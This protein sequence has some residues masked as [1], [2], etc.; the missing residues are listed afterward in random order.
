MNVPLE[1]LPGQQIEVAQLPSVS[2]KVDVKDN[3]N[4]DKSTNIQGANVNDAQVIDAKDN[5]GNS[6]EITAETAPEKDNLNTVIRTVGPNIKLPDNS[7][8]NITPS[9]D[10]KYLIETDAR[11]TNYKKWLSSIDIVTNEQLHKRLGDG[12]YEQRLVRD[13]LVATT[14]QRLLGNYQSDEEQYRHLLTNGVAFGETFNLTPGIALTPEQMANLTTDI[15]WMVNKEVTLP[16]GRVEKVSVPQVYVRAR[17]GDLNGNGALLAGRNVSVD[18]AGDI[19]NS[20]E[21]SSRELIDLRAENI[22]NSG[23]IQGKNVQLNALKD[24]HNVGGEIRG[25]DNVSLSAG[26]DIT[27]ETAQRTE[28]DAKWLDRPAS[29]YVTGD[30]GQLTLKAIQDINLIASDLGNLGVNGKNQYHRR[31]RY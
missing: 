10:S 29:I 8:F 18:M 25:L 7:L 4:V 30:N 16:D 2:T 3:Q 5:A 23:S 31:E 14:G 19:L 21:I 12:F 20:G 15:V 1:L 27:S 28:G 26:R 17:Q 13:Q 11:F 9:S 24:I 6:K 22:Q